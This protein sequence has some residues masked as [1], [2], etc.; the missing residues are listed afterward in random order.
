MAS[1]YDGSAAMSN[2]A[3]MAVR[4]R[5]FCTSP[6][7]DKR[8]SASRTVADFGES[9]GEPSGQAALGLVEQRSGHQFQVQDPVLEL[10]MDIGCAGAAWTARI[11]G[12]TL[13]GWLTHHGECRVWL[14]CSGL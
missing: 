5:K 9:A 8:I 6:S 7:A 12:G 2:W 1:K 13:G 11:A 3:T 10:L 14:R 4:L